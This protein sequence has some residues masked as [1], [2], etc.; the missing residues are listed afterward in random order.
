MADYCLFI[1]GCS[2]TW[3]ESLLLDCHR[4]FCSN[5]SI[6]DMDEGRDNIFADEKVKS[7]C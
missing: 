2:G 1:K 7:Y 5:I 6:N 3:Y 4:T